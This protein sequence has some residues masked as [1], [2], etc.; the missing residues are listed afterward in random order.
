MPVIAFT[1]AQGLLK[2]AEDYKARKQDKPASMIAREAIQTAE[3]SRL[4]ALER[5]EQ[6]RLANERR[7]AAEREAAV[8][9]VSM[10]SYVV[11]AAGDADELCCRGG[12]VPSPDRG[13]RAH[14]II[15]AIK[16]RSSLIPAPR[17]AR[18]AQPSGT[19]S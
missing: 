3:D 13:E 4:I 7:A 5:Q 9:W 6:E 15:G 18:S 19:G 1:K 8:R 11:P 14:L 17:S 10:A 2:Q 12:R 16:P